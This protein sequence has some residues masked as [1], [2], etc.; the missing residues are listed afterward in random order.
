MLSTITTKGQ[1]TIPKSIR[2]RLNLQTGDKV[3]FIVDQEG[4]IKLLPVT[5]SIKKL[6]GI[7]PKPKTTVRLEE[8]QNAIN[9]EGG[10][11]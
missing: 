8:M 5:A 4:Q 7:L 6:K 10:K 1:I 2:K 9:Y 3:E 11:L